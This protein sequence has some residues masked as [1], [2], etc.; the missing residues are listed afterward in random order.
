MS[1]LLLRMRAFFGTP[2]LIWAS[3]VNGMYSPYSVST[4][5]GVILTQRVW[6]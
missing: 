3:K 5:R 2:K 1:D 4:P 6:L